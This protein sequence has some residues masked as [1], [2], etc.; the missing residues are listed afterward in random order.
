MEKLDLYNII[1]IFILRKENTVRPRNGCTFS[2]CCVFSHFK[3]CTT[4]TCNMTDI[5]ST[6]KSVLWIMHVERAAVNIYTLVYA[7]FTLCAS[8]VQELFSLTLPSSR[9]LCS[10][11]AESAN[12]EL[13]CRVQIFICVYLCV[14]LIHFTLGCS[15]FVQH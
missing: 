3:G 1:I 5:G 13:H 15:M 14:S 7:D 11:S 9:S 12:S 8:N 2:L 4:C 6:W 10:P